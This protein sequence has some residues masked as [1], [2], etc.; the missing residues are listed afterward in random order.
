[1][2]GTG[3]AGEL[4]DGGSRILGLS[5]SLLARGGGRGR[6]GVVGRTVVWSRGLGGGANVGGG[7]RLGRR[8][9]RRVSPLVAAGLV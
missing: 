7:G 3:D 1:M 9:R 4:R 8:F 6:G 2:P 5:L